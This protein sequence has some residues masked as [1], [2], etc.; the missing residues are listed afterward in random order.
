MSRFTIPSAASL[1]LLLIVGCG[2][3]SESSAGAGTDS[4]PAANESPTTSADSGADSAA[5]EAKPAAGETAVAEAKAADTGPVEVKVEG[6]SFLVPASWKRVMPPSSR[7]VDAEF[8]IPR[9]EGDE[10]DGRLT[11]M[12]AGGDNDA[13]IAR[14]TG[15]FNQPP[16]QGAK[17]ETVKIAGSEAIWVD[18]RGE[19]K[20]SSFNRIEPRPDYR[21]IALIIPFN[22]RS[23]Y[24]LKLTG[25]RATIAGVEEEFKTFAKSA[26]MRE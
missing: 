15:E 19:W 20:G 7:I 5:A 22:E 2:G 24:F 14:W 11:M 16:G 21:M 1:A 13:N 6:F 23:S 26:R 25:P 4:A 9:A 3:A 18:I 10:F 12:A 8:T 17:V